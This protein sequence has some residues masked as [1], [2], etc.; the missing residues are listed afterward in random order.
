MKFV[1]Q[2]YSWLTLK[3]GLREAI[4]IDVTIIMLLDGYIA[5]QYQWIILMSLCRN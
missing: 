5:V 4:G 1:Y 2:A 3:Q